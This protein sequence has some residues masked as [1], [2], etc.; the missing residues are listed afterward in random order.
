MKPLLGVL[1]FLFTFSAAPTDVAPAQQS[2]PVATYISV[3]NV[4]AA[5][6]RSPQLAVNPQPNIHVV[7]AGGYNVAVGAIHRPQSPPGVAAVHFKV[8]E[9]Y[10]VID[11]G[12]TLVTGGTLVNAKPRP[13]DSESVKFEDGPG[14]SGSGIQGGTSQQI[15]AGDVV[16]IPA[17]T[18]H[19]FSAIDGSISYLVVRVDPNRI[20]PL[21]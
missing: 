7:D 20:L 11:G 1:A 4:Q 12:A 3:A 13:A 21:K 8:T 10:H 2:S 18:P 16:V 14:E 17:G 15:K 9:I 6:G 19:W 5:L